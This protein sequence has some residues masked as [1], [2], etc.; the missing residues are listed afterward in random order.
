MLGVKR[1]ESMTG[2]SFEAT[3]LPIS[4]YFPATG[5]GLAMDRV[6]IRAGIAVFS[7]GAV[8]HPGKGRRLGTSPRLSLQSAPMMHTAM[9][10]I[11]STY[12]TRPQSDHTYTAQ[13]NELTNNLTWRVL[14]EGCSFVYRVLF[15]PLERMASFVYR[16]PGRSSIA[17]FSRA[18]LTHVTAYFGWRLWQLPDNSL[19]G[20]G[21]F[22]PIKTVV[23]RGTIG[24][25]CG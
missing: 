11:T 8:C 25:F 20:G 24:P 17:C 10:F 22:S 7:L 4:G 16:V 15:G 3:W 12:E 13:L 14:I 18:I 23:Y 21:R 1:L 5:P 9:P 6:K 19:E 2:A